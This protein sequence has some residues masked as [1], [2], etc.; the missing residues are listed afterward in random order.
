MGG[1]AGWDGIY[2]DAS[3]APSLQRRSGAG[4]TAK[5]EEQQKVEGRK[6]SPRSQRNALRGSHGTSMTEQHRKKK[7]PEPSGVLGEAR[8]VVFFGKCKRYTRALAYLFPRRI[9]ASIPFLVQL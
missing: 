4:T 3:P 7:K 8:F 5:R 1:G 6:G 2:G 9:A